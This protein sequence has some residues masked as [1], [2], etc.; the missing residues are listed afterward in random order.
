MAAKQGVMDLI[1]SVEKSLLSV[2]YRDPSQRV[3]C[4]ADHN[5]LGLLL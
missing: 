4:G 3:L 1:D 5:G 2:E